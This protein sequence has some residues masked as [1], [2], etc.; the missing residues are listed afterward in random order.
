MEK[1]LTIKPLVCKI[2]KF[3]W[4]PRKIGDLPVQCP[5]CKGYKWN[6]EKKKNK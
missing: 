4:Y 1:T 6:E 3:S 5:K 2:C